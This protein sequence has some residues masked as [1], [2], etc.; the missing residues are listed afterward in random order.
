MVEER[1][2][3]KEGRRGMMESDTIV[4]L[5]YH[6]F[7]PCAA[8]TVFATS[9]TCTLKQRSTTHFPGSHIAQGDFLILPHAL[10]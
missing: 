6:P 5:V 3:I 8:L 4:R 7:V 9:I 2:E 10:H 1:A